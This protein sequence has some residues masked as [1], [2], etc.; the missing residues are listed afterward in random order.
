MATDTL[1]R[2]APARRPATLLLLLPTA[3]LIV[4]LFAT[5]AMHNRQLQAQAERFN[6]QLTA[7]TAEHNQQLV[8]MADEYN[9]RLAARAAEIKK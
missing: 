5:T 2:A 7:M 9:A 6:A 3:F 4:V 1:S 8:K